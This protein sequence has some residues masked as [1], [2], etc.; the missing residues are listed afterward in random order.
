MLIKKKN[1][2]LLILNKENKC[3]ADFITCIVESILTF[4]CP[5][6][7]LKDTDINFKW[8][9]SEYLFCFQV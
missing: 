1:Y 6:I 3:L 4:A 5:K 9:N 2:L 8:Q 7:M